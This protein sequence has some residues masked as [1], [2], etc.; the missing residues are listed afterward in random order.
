MSPQQDF[1]NSAIA[2]AQ[3][4][5][6]DTA[7]PAAVTIAQAI[8]ESGWGVHHL[9]DANNYFGIK[10]STNTDGSVNY[11]TVATGYVVRTTNETVNGKVV[12]I[13]AKFRKYA[14]MADS[15]KD[16]GLFLKNNS[17]YA[18]AFTH[19]SDPVQFAKD[20]AAAGYATEPDYADE[21]VKIINQ[22]K[23]DQYDKAAATA[24]ATGSG[25]GPDSGSGSGSSSGQSASAS[26]S[27]F[28]A[29]QSFASADSTADQSGS[30]DQ[31][32]QSGSDSSD[33][34]PA[35]GDQ[36]GSGDTSSDSTDTSDQSD[37]SDTSDQL[38]GSD[39]S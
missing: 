2:P 12:T 19:A 3:L 36:S 26:A 7:V 4:S 39:Q 14:S 29:D 20:I 38:V 10:A 37:S 35:T 30:G 21:L 23:L 34:G 13:Q 33:A 16:H 27:P 28:G 1:I 18:T 17:R 24:P 11:G 25:S 6:K 32:D 22:W 5:K 9:D 31:S 15:F 8:L